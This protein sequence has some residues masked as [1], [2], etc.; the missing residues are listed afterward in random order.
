LIFVIVSNNIAKRNEKKSEEKKGKSSGRREHLKINKKRIFSLLIFYDYNI[1]IIKSKPKR[2]L[3][4]EVGSF[5]IFAFFLQAKCH[6]NQNKYL[7]Q[8]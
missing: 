8:K 2:S 7:M 6:I 4:I 3:I 1:F 5:Q